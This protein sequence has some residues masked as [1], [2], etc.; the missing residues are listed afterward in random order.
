MKKMAIIAVCALALCSCGERS[1]KNVV[2]QGG[3]VEK[4]EV[5]IADS[6][7]R[8][9]GLGNVEEF[10][11]KGPVPASDT[12]GEHYTLK[13]YRQQY[14]DDGV[15]DLKQTFLDAKDGLNQS[16]HTYGKWL[17]IKGYQSDSTATLYRLDPDDDASPINF[18]VDGDK[19][20][21]LDGQPAHINT[22]PG[23]TL[24]ME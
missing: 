11:Y 8:V 4:L 16:Y 3:I 15:F 21:R 18:L 10:V 2:T 6:L 23:F 17:T 1:K 14:A 12:P 5:N 13:L 19:L 7:R 20:H 22:R 24:I 9:D